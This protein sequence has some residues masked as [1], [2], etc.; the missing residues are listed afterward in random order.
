M[1]NRGCKKKLPP[2]IKAIPKKSTRRP[3]Q[4]CERRRSPSSHQAAI[5]TQRGEMLPI[6]AALATFV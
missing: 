1:P 6:I 2:M 5:E 3:I 4:N